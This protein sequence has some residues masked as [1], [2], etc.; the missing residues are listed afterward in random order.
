M[1]QVASADSSRRLQGGN[2]RSKVGRH[3]A[4]RRRSPRAR[5]VLHL[6]PILG[7]QFSMLPRASAKRVVNRFGCAI[8]SL[9]SP[10]ETELPLLSHGC[11]SEQTPSDAELPLLVDGCD[12]E[13]TPPGTELPLSVDG[14][15]V[16]ASPSLTV[17]WPGPRPCRGPDLDMPPEE[18]ACIVH[19]AV[20]SS[21]LATEPWP[22]LGGCSV[23]D[24]TRVVNWLSA[25]WNAATSSNDA[26]ARGFG[27]GR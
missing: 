7:K 14:V 21:V 1:S 8:S 6:C 17:T 2:S 9:W 10:S 13:Q 22:V 4:K 3:L 24:R 26:K 12:C 5:F 20:H 16:V 15:F 27:A 19:V 18:G 11:D 25:C 23:N